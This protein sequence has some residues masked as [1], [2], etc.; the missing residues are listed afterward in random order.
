MDDAG[1]TDPREIHLAGLRFADH[2]VGSLLGLL[3]A[4]RA[5]EPFRYAVNPNVDCVVRL[6]GDARFAA[7]CARAW[8]VVNDSRVLSL[9]ARLLAGKRLRAVP[10]SDL[11]RLFLEERAVPGT[12]VTIV[13]GE[14][15]V[16]DIVR[17]RTRALIQHH[18]PPMGFIRDPGAVERAYRFVRDNPA[19]VVL[20]AVGSPQQEL[21]AM[22]LADRGGCV[23]LGICCGAAVNL[24][25][26]AEPRAPLWMRRLAL[27]WLHRLAGDPRRLWRRYLVRSPRIVALL[28]RSEW[29]ARRPRLAL[30]WRDPGGLRR[31][32]RT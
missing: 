3:G 2:S 26:G 24:L 17:A 5:A 16:V 23:G 1:A 12:T 7:A 8:L 4:A 22:H 18:N 11:V 6:A 32:R 13:G 10:G 27:E 31:P 29:A 21:L 30:P 9:L 19:D 25:A 20:L 15:R 14:P 28:V